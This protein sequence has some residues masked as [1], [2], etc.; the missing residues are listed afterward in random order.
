ML[1]WTS[2]FSFS[3]GV[4]AERGVEEDLLGVC[5]FFLQNLRF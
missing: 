3:Q 4:T 1:A 5:F 2:D